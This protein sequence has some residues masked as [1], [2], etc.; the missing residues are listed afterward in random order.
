M[1]QKIN[2]VLSS[3]TFLLLLAGYLTDYWLS[4]GTL[5][6]HSGLHKACFFGICIKIKTISDSLDEDG[7]DLTHL[8]A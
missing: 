2:V 5:D 8:Y 4:V 3:L 1:H 6:I 7:K